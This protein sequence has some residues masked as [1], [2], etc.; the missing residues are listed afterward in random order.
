MNNNMQEN[1]NSFFHKY[2]ATD[3]HG[4][5]DENEIYLGNTLNERNKTTIPDIFNYQLN[6]TNQKTDVCN[7]TNEKNKTYDESL[8]ILI[9][10]EREELNNLNKSIKIMRKEVRLAT[11]EFINNH[12]E[13]VG[14]NAINKSR[15]YL[16]QKSNFLIRIKH[17]NTFINEYGCTTIHLP[18]EEY[19]DEFR[20]DQNYI[21]KF[22]YLHDLIRDYNKMLAVQEEAENATVKYNTYRYLTDLKKTIETRESVKA[23]IYNILL[24][25]KL[26]NNFTQTNNLENVYVTDYT[27]QLLNLSLWEFELQKKTKE[28]EQS[29][30]YLQVE[31]FRVPVQEYIQ[32]TIQGIIFVTGFVGNGALVLIFARQKDARTTSNMMLLNLAV[33]DLLN[34]ITNIPTFYYY[35]M[36]TKWQLGLHLCKAYRFLRQLGIGVSVYSIVVISVQR[37]I[38]VTESNTFRSYR[39]RISKNL[40]LTLTILAVWM[41]GCMIA[42]P[43]TVYAGIYEGNCYG[44]SSE[45]HYYP[46]AI[47]LLDLLFF[48]LIPLAIII[49]LSVVSAYQLKRSV[50]KLPGE[51]VGMEKLI[52]AR[53]VS[54]NIL[55]VLAILSAVSYIP[56]HLLFFLYAWIDFNMSQSTYYVI[57]LI[58]YSLLFGN[59]CFNPI[60]LYI[61]ST[62]FRGY[63]NTY[64]FCRAERKLSENQKQTSTGIS[65]ITVEDTL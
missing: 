2:I 25:V 57:F 62:K 32:P 41:I 10:T 49:L 50:Q 34:L 30:I 63:F 4:N 12:D 29:N 53:N 58:V 13:N 21:M 38:A 40:K 22:K 20:K 16:Q 27:T 5:A 33:G 15:E 7:K 45:H 56:F 52:Q 48:C 28:L 14:Y 64:L 6:S 43:H 1:N 24:D 42:V 60:A 18:E 11:W 37:F 47:T 35:S 19:E 55:I 3:D 54:S 23:M 31:S 44:A 9:E 59:S 65:A 51:A 46:K 26:I 8:K 61:V 17:I 36:S 39:C